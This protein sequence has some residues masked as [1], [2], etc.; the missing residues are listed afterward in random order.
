[1][2]SHEGVQPVSCTSSQPGGCTKSGRGP[3][4]FHV[5]KQTCTHVCWSFELECAR[6][7]A[8][9]RAVTRTCACTC[10]HTLIVQAWQH[11]VHA[12]KSQAARH[13]ATHNRQHNRQHTTGN[14]QQATQ[15]ATHQQ[16][17]PNRQHATHNTHNTHNTHHTHKLHNTRNAHITHN[18]LATAARNIRSRFGSI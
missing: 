4:S 15:Q 10:I 8:H 5:R 1:M 17:T 12:N 3:R 16:T 11:A 9:S 6:I 7:L 14:T 13:Q 18:M 2:G